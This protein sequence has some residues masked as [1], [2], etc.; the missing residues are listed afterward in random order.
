MLHT[1]KTQT[2]KGFTLIELMIVVVIIGILAAIAIPAY[3]NYSNRAKASEGLSLLSSVKT[4]IAEKY[5][6]NGNM[7]SVATMTTDLTDVATN[8]TQ[9]SGITYARTDDDNS[10]VTITYG[11]DLDNGTLV[12]NI[13]GGAG[14][15]QVACNAGTSTLNT[16]YRP[17]N[18]KAS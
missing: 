12:Y 3:L 4:N 7:P 6:A 15:I 11:A 13:G 18:C 5:M 8:S 17:A 2:Q 14:G 16:D 10:V 1:R 9:V